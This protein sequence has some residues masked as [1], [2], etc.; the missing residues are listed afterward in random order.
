MSHNPSVRLRSGLRGRS[1]AAAFAAIGTAVVA[2][3]LAAAPVAT[4][5]P[6]DDCPLPY[7]VTSVEKGMEVTGR[8]VVS[9]TEPQD[10]DGEILGVI[11]DGIAP[12]FDMIMARL[13]SREIDRVGGIWQ[14]M[15]GSPVYASDGRLI[16]AVA[17]GL[18]YGP[19]PVAG[20]TPA[21]EMYR[22][23]KAA[24]T[25][26]AASSA[27]TAAGSNKTV[28][29]PQPMARNLVS[30]GVVA[31][32]E[33]GSGMSRLPVPL[34]ISGMVSERRLNQA[35]KAFG[36]EGVHVYQGGSVSTADA[37]IAVEPG[38]NLAASLSFGDVSA[39]GVGTATAVCGDEVVG[40]GHRMSFT[41]PS[42]MTMH[43]ADALYIQEDSLGAPFKVANASA[44]VGSIL[45]DRGAG[46]A[47]IQSA[48]AVPRTTSVTS[49]VEVPGEWSRTGTTRI[50]VADAVPD[51]SAFHLMADED[52]VFDA[53]GRGSAQVSWLITGRR[54]DGRAFSL[55]REDRFASGTD[56]TFDTSFDLYDQLAQL[57][58][59]DVEDVTIDAVNTKSTMSRKYAA[60]SVAKVRVF[61]GGRWRPLRSNQPLFVRHSTT[62][63]FAVLLTSR[64]LGPTWVKVRVRVPKHVGMKSGVIEF[65]GGNAFLPDEEGEFSEEGYGTPNAP[66]TW[67]SLMRGL[68]EQPRNDAVLANLMLFKRDGSVLKRSGRT[69]ARAVVNGGVTIPVQGIG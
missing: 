41:G 59:N 38:G 22:L 10:F 69:T 9:G 33:A 50:S 14:G 7:P 28:D 25:D 29:I 56:I 46:I 18:S 43:G 3:G 39:V 23:I 17:Y 6:S 24:P 5:A 32:Q 64:Q 8:T 1:R 37:P 57:Q 31:R 21:A 51:I 63:R 34:G 61:A 4:S 13:S 15:S 30:S 26:A 68:R 49:S 42:Q 55:E 35:A 67:Q 52:R 53:V 40:F 44:P 48:S 11:H 54:A 16:G 65:L 20:I 66:E 47:G 45:Q 27:L 58:F 62:K 60:Y 36:L 19:S 2:S 12:G